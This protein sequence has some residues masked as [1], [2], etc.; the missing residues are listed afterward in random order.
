MQKRETSEAIAL[1]KAIEDKW[2]FI[3]KV[4]VNPALKTEKIG[5]GEKEALSLALKHKYTLIIDDDSAKE[6]ASIF[7][8]EAHGTFYVIYLACIKNIIRKDDALTILKSM[9]A[10]GFYVSAE[11]YSKFYLLLDSIDNNKKQERGI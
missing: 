10:N 11:A 7:G 1:T 9:I 5:Q 2:L 4:D 3:E 6:Y 8:V